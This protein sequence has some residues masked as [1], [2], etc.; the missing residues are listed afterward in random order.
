VVAEDVNASHL[1]ALL[2]E[3]ARRSPPKTFASLESLLTSPDLFG[4]TTA[5]PVQRA[6]CRVA[7]GVPLGDLATDPVV[8]DAFGEDIVK[9]RERPRELAILSGIR[10]GKSLIAALLGIYWSQTCDLSKLGPGETPRVSIVSITRDL[11]EVV[12]GHVLGRI[13]ASKKLSALLVGSPTADSV[14][15]RHPS[16]IPVEISVVS[17]TRAG[18]SLV[19]RWSA[20]CIFDEFPRMMG[21]D[22]SVINW[23]DSRRAVLERIVPNAQLV[24]IGSPWAPYGPAFDVY[25]NHWKRPTSEMVV[26]KTPAWNFNPYFWT[27]D[28]VAKAKANPDIYQTDVLAEFAN[29]EESLFSSAEVDSATRTTP[30]NLPPESRFSYRAAMDPATRGNGWTLVIV[31]RQGNRKKVVYTEEWRGSRA[32]P[33]SPKAVMIEMSAILKEYGITSIDTDQYSADA[34]KD[35]AKDQ[36]I[37]VRQVTMT[38]REKNR[39]WMSF[40]AKMALGEVEISADRKFRADLLHVK[41]KSTSSG[42]KIILPTTPDGRHCD[43]AP[44]LLL[45]MSAYL[46]DLDP[47]AL[48]PGSPQY[49]QSMADKMKAERFKAVKESQRKDGQHNLWGLKR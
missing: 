38:D 39:K 25:T 9:L 15:L 31:T 5:T 12:F 16:G 6:I 32:Q 33:L 44:S 27:P 29:P 11:A 17:G 36:G 43:Y 19:A 22:D 26:V 4:L 41:K 47:L 45:A 34:I 10:V 7:D 14:T 30:I 49:F 40:K 13:M 2:A 28:R 3:K 37:F 42:I 46:E 35:I 1:R 48:E 24:S 21:A 18:S 8:L 23:E 20:G